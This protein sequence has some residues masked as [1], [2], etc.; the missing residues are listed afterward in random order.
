[1]YVHVHKHVHTAAEEDKIIDLMYGAAG[2]SLY[3]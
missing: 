1:M 3:I 2:L